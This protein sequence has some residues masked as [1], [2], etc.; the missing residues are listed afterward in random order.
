MKK[1]IIFV[2]MSLVISVHMLNAQIIL[3]EALKLPIEQA[4]NR[5]KE[6]ENKKINLEIAEKDLEMIKRK[7]IPQVDAT[8]GYTYTYN[9]MI[10]DL[11]T[12][13][14]PISGAE[15]FA[16]RSE[17]HTSELQSRGHLVCR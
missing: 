11:P 6:I 15:L 8:A 1:N 9:R 2:L 12:L 13:E 16:D 3:P 4:I 17:E 7:Y 14:L 10:L 5:S